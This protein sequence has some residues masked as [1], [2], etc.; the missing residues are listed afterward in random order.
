[1]FNFKSYAVFPS[2]K[3]RGQCFKEFEKEL[4]YYPLTASLPLPSSIQYYDYSRLY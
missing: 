1:M 2:N 3:N 4:N